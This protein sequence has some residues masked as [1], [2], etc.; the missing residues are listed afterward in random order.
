V[1]VT[2]T[3]FR[4]APWANVLYAMDRDWWKMHIAEVRKTFLGRLC[5]P[6]ADCYGA[7]QVA[8]RQKNSGAGAIALASQFGARRVLLLGYDCSTNFGTH[9]HGDHPKGLGNAQNAESWPAQFRELALQL[10]GRVTVVNCSRYTQLDAFPK[11]TLPAELLER[12]V[13]VEGMNGMGDNLHQRSVVRELCKS[14]HVWLRTPW[15]SLYHDLPVKFLAPSTNL[16]TQNKN[17]AAERIKYSAS[18]PAHSHKLR[19]HYPPATVRAK[20][21]VLA[22]MS[23]ECGV[24]VGDFSLPVPAEWDAEVPH[25][26]TGGRPILIYRPLVERKEWGGCR[27]RNPDAAAYKALLE[28][29]REGFCVVSV[30][31]LV[32]GVEWRVDYDIHADVEFHTGELSVR[33]LAALWRRA[34]LVFTAPGFAVP[35]AQSVGTPVAAVFG[36]YEDSRSFMSGNQTPYLGID[37]VV[38]CRCFSHTHNCNKSINLDAARQRLLE[39]KNE[40][41][42]Q[43]AVCQD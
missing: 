16:R 29:V 25:F 4:A 1:I 33:A 12:V 41:C 14:A 30:A 37:T 2:N 34:A 20:G 35:L 39:F 17:A 24:P 28:S 40:H 18:V 27:N 21:S 36:G 42:S 11:G 10:A 15:P 19:V 5:T 31:D 38:P 7:E 22:A 23:A 3:T 43:Q 8:V 13:V 32:P 6:L 9:W 26:E